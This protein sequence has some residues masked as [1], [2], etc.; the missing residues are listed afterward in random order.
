MCSKC[1]EINEKIKHF[2]DLGTR[3]LD[4][5]AL[6][7]LETLIADLEANKSALHPERDA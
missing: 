7:S 3:I 4:P 1:V 5:Q 2:R 6:R